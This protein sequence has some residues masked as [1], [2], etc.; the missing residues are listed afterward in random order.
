M[1]DRGQVV[2]RNAQLD[3]VIIST[4]F[5]ELRVGSIFPRSVSVWAS[6]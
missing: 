5:R 6:V 3:G 1:F 2:P 4:D